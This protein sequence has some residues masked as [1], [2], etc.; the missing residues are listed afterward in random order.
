MDLDKIKNDAAEIVANKMH[1]AN[2]PPNN[3]FLEWMMTMIINKGF[4]VG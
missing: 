1:E 2:R 3:F 4:A